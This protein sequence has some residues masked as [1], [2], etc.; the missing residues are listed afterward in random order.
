M[1]RA[2]EKL[3]RR[4][5]L[6]GFVGLDFMIDRQNGKPLLIELNARPTQICH[7]A[8]DERSDMIG[9]LATALGVIPPTRRMPTVGAATIALFPQECWRDPH[10]AYLRSAYH[11]VPWSVPKFTAAYSLP[12]ASDRRRWLKGMMARRRSRRL[13]SSVASLLGTAPKPPSPV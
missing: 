13:L 4:L 9:G 6:S 1:S 8:L 12:P 10:S 2:A 5:G 11:D 7:M 3:V